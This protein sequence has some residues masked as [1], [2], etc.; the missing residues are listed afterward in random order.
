MMKRV[1]TALCLSLVLALPAHAQETFTKNVKIIVPFAAGGGIDVT[2]R[3]MTDLVPKYLDGKQLVVE[4][5]PGGGAVI[6]LTT[7]SKAKPDGY[8]LV[9]FAPS[10]LTN[11]LTKKTSFTKE[12]FIP[13]ILYCFDPTIIVVNKDSRI[14]DLKGLVAKA[15]AGPISISTAGHSNMQ[16]LCGMQLEKQLGLKFNYVHAASGGAQLP[17]ILGG[18]VD[19]ALMSLGEVASYLQDGSLRCVGLASDKEYPGFPAMD[20][21]SS[22]GFKVGSS[23]AEWGSSRGICAIAGTP[24][25]MLKALEKAFLGMVNDPAYVERMNKGGYPLQVLNTKEFTQLYEDLNEVLK[26][27]V[28]SLGQQ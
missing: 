19:A 14:K 6:G 21:L 4:N 3:M 10:T 22:A 13:V 2:I 18:H 16:H 20:R 24:E 27:T 8:T 17:Q 5:L 9:T 23:G 25:P 26:E 7:A 15:K 1:L 28:S 12:S 11:P